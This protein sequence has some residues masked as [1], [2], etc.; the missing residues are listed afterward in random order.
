MKKIILYLLFF[1]SCF[2]SFSQNYQAELKKLNDF[3]KTFDDGYYGYMEIKGGYLYDRFK[4][5]EHCK[6]LLSSLDR[7]VVAE[8]NRKVELKCKSG[9]NCV[10][11]T[12]TNSNHA[13]MS[14]SQ[15]TDFNTETLIELL[16][17]LIN[18]YNNKPVYATK[19][20]AE[21]I[22][23]QKEKERNKQD[24]N[25]DDWEDE[26]FDELAATVAPKNNNSGKTTSKDYK[27]QL[28]KLNEYLKTFDN[29]YYGYFEVKDGYIYDR[30]KAGKYNKF[31]MED[32]E[33]AVI[34]EEYKRVIL[35]CKGTNKCIETD[36]K[37]NGKEEYSQ[38]LTNGS[39]NY[40]EL[41]GLLNDFKAAYLGTNNQNTSSNIDFDNLKSNIDIM[42]PSSNSSS[43]TTKTGNYQT[44]L[45]A[46]NDY[47]KTFDGDRYQGIEVKDGYVYSRYKNNEF[48]KA[49][50]DDLDKVV[51]GAQ[52]SV[53]KLMC[54]NESKC[55]YSTITKG[56]HDYFNFQTASGKSIYKM[57]ELLKDFLAALQNKTNTASTTKT[58]NTTSTTK[59]SAE[60]KRE[61]KEKERQNNTS[62][63]SVFED[64]VF[65]YLFDTPI[66]T[67]NTSTT[68]TTSKT[69]DA[70]KY[71]S[72]LKALNDY[73][74]IFNPA[75]YKNVNVSN[76]KVNFDFK[77]FSKTYTSYIPI[78]D[79]VNKTNVVIAKSL[80]SNEV[81]IMCKNE[82]DCFY[83]TY[84]N[85]N[86]DHFR[87][88]SNNIADMTKMKQ[89]VDD[90]IKSLK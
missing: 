14:F 4:S 10:F 68:S 23:E 40:K 38:F 28:D 5:G 57:E 89:L 45:K 31:K 49:K 71:S 52:Y 83:S 76:G 24:N 25:D 35:K 51:L 70:S 26:D 12:Y 36:W 79:L 16:D 87:F 9:N 32:M 11:S 59:T 1:N 65:G 18:A 44:A 8:T 22:R 88:Y 6:A 69:P 39:F 66:T 75:T 2:A 27:K 63:S 64:D 20:A 60:I 30:F 58:T 54:K 3:L 53:V 86:T 43:T 29:G 72:K 56:Y 13:Q 78:D 50:I 47:L 90:F 84:S 48:S 7:A 81:K 74:K 61:Q 21:K 55:I 37:P 67:S 85:D 73:L 62:S 17:N 46:L 42:K 34:Q 19:T 80:T 77:I 33:G 41:A 82:S 15:N